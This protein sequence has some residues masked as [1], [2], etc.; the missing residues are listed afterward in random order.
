KRRRRINAGLGRCIDVGNSGTDRTFSIN[1]GG[2]PSRSGSFGNISSVPEFSQPK[3]LNR[4]GRGERPQRTRRVF[5]CGQQAGMLPTM[6]ATQVRRPI[7]TIAGPGSL[8]NAL[9]ISLHAAGYRISE[10]L[11]RPGKASRLRARALARQ[12]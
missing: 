6:S 5:A 10:I 11:S 12:V 2:S 3:I 7:I 8:G 9:A 1:F 4:R